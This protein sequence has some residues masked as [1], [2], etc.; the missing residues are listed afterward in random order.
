MCTLAGPEQTSSATGVV[1]SPMQQRL[2]SSTWKRRDGMVSHL[3]KVHGYHDKTEACKKA[4]SFRKSSEKQFWS[5][6]F[7]PFRFTLWKERVA[8]IGQHFEK[9][10]TLNGW[11]L[12]IEIQGL[13]CQPMVA[14]AWAQI[15]AGNDGS[16]IFWQSSHRLSRLRHLLQLGAAN[17]PSAEY[18]AQAAFAAS[19]ISPDAARYN[20]ISAIPNGYGD[21]AGG[22]AGDTSPIE[23]DGPFDDQ[24]F[25]I[26]P[27]GKR[28]LSR[29]RK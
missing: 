4:D 19:N 14:T 23:F 12:T 13:L 20:L 7:C 5:C 16:Q 1:H 21:V 18:L 26:D 22:M 24:Q 10:A 8:H 29:N 2:C 11:S 9:G 6:G 15:L 25:F 27:T 17:M 3:E 28:L